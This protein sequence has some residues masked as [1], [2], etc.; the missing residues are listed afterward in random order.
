[1]RVWSPAAWAVPR[2]RDGERFAQPVSEM[3][4][5]AGVAPIADATV[6]MDERT[7]N[8]TAN[9]GV[10]GAAD[11]WPLSAREAAQRLGVSERTVRRAIARGELPAAM[12]AGVYRI[13]P[14]DLD[15]YRAR[16]DRPSVHLTIPAVV[17]WATR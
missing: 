12:H 14:D 7:T 10:S 1:M 8:G 2:I 11:T 9:H 3:G 13:E 17:S 6:A 15:R 16:R 4:A 5:L